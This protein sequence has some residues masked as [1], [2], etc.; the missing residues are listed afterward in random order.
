MV[1]LGFLH[2]AQV[3]V[4][5]FDAL[6]RAAAA[7]ETVPETAH[8]V[9]P[10]LLERARANGATPELSADVRTALATLVAQGAD[11]VVC[12]CSTLGPIAERIDLPVPVVRVDRPMARAAVAAGSRIGVVAAL[13]STLTPTLELVADEAARAS[14]EPEVVTRGVP[15]AWAAFE[16]GDAAAYAEQIAAAARSLAASVDVI[17]LAQASMAGA[18]PLLA[19]LSVRVLASPRLAVDAALSAV[20]SPS[21]R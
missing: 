21:S 18:V 17:V 16:A 10:E 6:V 13:E 12:T 4:E 15:E 11:V 7:G 19:D 1:T 9:A 14:A 2:T 5:T 20:G 8:V 3:H